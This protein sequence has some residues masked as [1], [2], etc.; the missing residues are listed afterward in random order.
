MENEDKDLS[1]IVLSVLTGKTEQISKPDK[2][3]ESNKDT[4]TESAELENLVF[5]ILTEGSGDKTEAAKITLSPKTPTRPAK[6][7]LTTS[8][9]PGP[10]QSENI[11]NINQLINQL[12][13]NNAFT[14]VLSPAKAEILQRVGKFKDQ[15]AKYE[16]K[17]FND[18]KKTVVVRPVGSTDH[19]EEI[20]V[21]VSA[22]CP[23]NPVPEESQMMAQDL[24]DIA[25]DSAARQGS[26]EDLNGYGYGN[27]TYVLAPPEK[28]KEKDDY[29]S[30]DFKDEQNF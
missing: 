16:V 14:L 7:K 24:N 12:G 20:L 26:R 4:K 28:I 22:L 27:E 29:Y 13:Y 15:N 18:D 2:T 30:D 21:P 25:A 10:S 3:E 9:Q 1:D 8:P 19:R 17:T 11:K 6:Q 23:T 5:S